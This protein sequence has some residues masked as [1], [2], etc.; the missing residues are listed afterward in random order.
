[1]MSQERVRHPHIATKTE[2][3]FVMERVAYV[4]WKAER[5]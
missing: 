5:K 4:F 2:F 1:M 3:R